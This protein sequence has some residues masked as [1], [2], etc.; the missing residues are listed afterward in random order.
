MCSIDYY[1]RISFRGSLNSVLY[2]GDE[3]NLAGGIKSI[4]LL[5]P[6][7]LPPGTNEALVEFWVEWG[8]ARNKNRANRYLRLGRKWERSL[9]QDGVLL[10]CGVK[11]VINGV[12][13]F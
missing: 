4:G 9:G 7:R 6:Y 3:S 13:C 8:E 5:L 1:G 12:N 2:V 10:G 11:P